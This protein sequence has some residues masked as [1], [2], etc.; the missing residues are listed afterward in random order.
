MSRR[1]SEDF[2]EETRDAAR[3]LRGMHRR[4]AIT[5]TSSTKWQLLGQRGGQG[6]DERIELELFPGIGVY[7]RPPATGRPE[8]VTAAIGG[9]K[10]S[11][12]V[13]TR[14]EKTRQA[15]AKS[16][17]EDETIVFNSG[18]IVLL[19]ANGTVEIRTPVG[20]AQPTIKGT[21]YRTAEDTMLTSLAAALTALST[22]AA[23]QVAT[24][25]ACGNAATAIGTF[26]AAAATYLTT[27]LKGQ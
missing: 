8:A 24:K 20:V 18:V 16:I 17:A 5:R 12:I 7:A 15:V 1:G 6:G 13:A 10:T 14:D 19:K 9:A 3:L 11:V 21:T 23:L 26:Q 22:D 27:V 25:T 4:M 2:A